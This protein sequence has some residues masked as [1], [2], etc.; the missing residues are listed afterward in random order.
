M[1]SD[2]KTSANA[3]NAQKSTGPKSAKGKAIASKNALKHGMTAPPPWDEVTRMYR[4]ILEDMTAIPDPMSGD[5]TSRT[6]LA[7]AEAEAQLARCVS[8]ER[9]LLARIAER[10]GNGSQVSIDAVMR[11]AGK[12]IYDLDVMEVLQ[13]NETDPTMRQILKLLIQ[14]DPDRPAELR[15]RYKVARRYRREAEARRRRALK[16]WIGEAEE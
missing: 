14:S 1:M 11:K 5:L 4:L 7:L 6:A 12:G 10:A 9:A 16:N 8:H 13:K 15:R 2:H 3:A